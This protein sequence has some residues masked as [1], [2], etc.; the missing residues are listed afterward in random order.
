MNYTLSTL[1]EEL[2]IHELFGAQ[3]HRTPG[4]VA[5]V[6]E[7]KEMTYRELDQRANQLAHYLISQRV[8]VESLVAI[9]L[10]RSFEMFIGILGIQKAG[11]AYVPIDPATPA[12]RWSFI[13]S[14]TQ[15]RFCLT[16]KNLEN[17]ITKQPELTLISLD[18]WGPMAN[19]PTTDPGIKVTPQ[20][21]IYTIYTSG[22]T[23]QP[24]GVQVE[25]HSVRNLIQAQINYVKHPV[26]RFLYAYSFAFDGAVLLIYWTLLDG[27]TLVIAPEN[28]EKD[29]SNL[30]SF[31]QN[32]QISHLLTFPSLYN[33]IL[34]EAQ[35]TRLNT[36]ESVSVAGET[37]PH[38][39][40]SR[41]LF[42]FYHSF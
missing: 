37:C 25:H 19:F 31:I 34:N 23:G 17:K 26:K 2:C 29:I 16:Q 11:A 32:Q 5:L 7:E 38:S 20:N 18:D 3:A 33:L 6:Y 13:L 28:L 14:D 39:L 8:T 22:S 30:T 40:V 1:P 15:A 12:E 9:S 41:R 10:D 35:P 21:L 36:L 42:Y 24:K 27:G 4:S